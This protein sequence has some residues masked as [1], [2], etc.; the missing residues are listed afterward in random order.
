[1]KRTDL[2]FLLPSL[3]L[4]CG[5]SAIGQDESSTADSATPAST[6]EVVEVYT[7]EN[8]SFFQPEE[9]DRNPFWQIG[10]Q[11]EKSDDNSGAAPTPVQ[12]LTQVPPDLFKLSSTLTGSP[13]I[14]VIDGRDYMVGQV[15]EK[16]VEGRRVQFRIMSIRDGQVVL[17]FEGGAVTIRNF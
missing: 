9:L 2:F 14:A 11:P 5:S 16:E 15:L 3:L 4:I 12:R 13:A 8:K 1:M 7:P 17:A 6:T 10:W